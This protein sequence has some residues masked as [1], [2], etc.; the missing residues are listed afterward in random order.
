MT[1]IRSTGSLSVELDECIINVRRGM[2]DD[3]G[4]EMVII[5]IYPQ[6]DWESDGYTTN[7]MHRKEE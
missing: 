2:R 3:H 1:I 5:E 4:K 7:I 6:G